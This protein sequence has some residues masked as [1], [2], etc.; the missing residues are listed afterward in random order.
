MKNAAAM[1]STR[2]AQFDSTLRIRTF[3]LDC[4]GFAAGDSGATGGEVIGLDYGVWW[5]WRC[6]D[7]PRHPVIGSRGSQTAVSRLPEARRALAASAS[8]EGIFVNWLTAMQGAP[9]ARWRVVQWLWRNQTME[10]VR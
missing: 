1:L 8:S 7:R 6:A 10:N 4:L 9:L 2:P 3:E 5:M